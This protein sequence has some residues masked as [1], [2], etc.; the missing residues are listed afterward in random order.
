MDETDTRPVYGRLRRLDACG[1]RDKMF[2]RIIKKIGGGNTL[3]YPGCLTKFVL[4]EAV[5][6]YKKILTFIGHIPD[7]KV[8]TEIPFLDALKEPEKLVDLVNKKVAVLVE[9]KRKREEKITIQIDEQTLPLGD[10]VQGIT[11]NTVLAMV[12]SLKGVKIKGEEKVSIVI[13]RLSKG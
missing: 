13:K 11:R 2:D 10:F 6:R 7:G 4:P 12:S 3:Y 5:E 9:R 1:V 8:E